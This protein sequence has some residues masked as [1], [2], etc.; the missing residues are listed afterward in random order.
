MD[1]WKH[2]LARSFGRDEEKQSKETDHGQ[3]A[4]RFAIAHAV[5]ND[6]MVAEVGQVLDLVPPAIPKV[7]EAMDKEQCFALGI[8]FFH[9]VYKGEKCRQFFSPCPGGEMRA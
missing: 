3:E 1:P 2:L 7:R 6:D 5:D 8:A 9:I 4:Y